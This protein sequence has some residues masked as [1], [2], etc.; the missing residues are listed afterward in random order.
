[1]PHDKKKEKIFLILIN[2]Q[3]ILKFYYLHTNYFL[4]YYLITHSIIDWGLKTHKKITQ[5]SNK[6]K[7][8]QKFLI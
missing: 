1:M 4:I 7:M 2:V 3:K 8:P 5:L 6:I